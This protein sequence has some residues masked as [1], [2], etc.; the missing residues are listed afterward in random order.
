MARTTARHWLLPCPS[1]QP[2]RAWPRSSALVARGESVSDAGWQRAGRATYIEVIG[3]EDE[4]LLCCHPTEHSFLTTRDDAAPVVDEHELGLVR[5]GRAWCVQSDGISAL[6]HV[7]HHELRLRM[8]YPPHGSNPVSVRGTRR[9]MHDITHANIRTA[10][11]TEQERERVSVRQQRDTPRASAK[12]EQA[13]LVLLV[14]RQQPQA[15]GRVQVQ[16]RLGTLGW[17]QVLL[18]PVE[19]V[20][21]RGPGLGG[22]LVQR[23]HARPLYAR[24]ERWPYTRRLLNAWRGTWVHA[25]EISH[26][27]LRGAGLTRR[28][29]RFSSRDSV[30]SPSRHV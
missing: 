12:R 4:Q 23:P 3:C 29:R 6:S 28:W 5:C 18:R 14:G 15:G 17:W 11:R 27:P 22:R 19:H 10:R 13:H 24:V 21:Q 2:S 8:S 30:W 20:A 16:R 1:S 7:A 25:R 26:V 9:S